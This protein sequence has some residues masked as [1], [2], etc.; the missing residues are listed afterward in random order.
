MDRCEPCLSNM[1]TCLSHS[2]FPSAGAAHMALSI[3]SLTT[4]YHCEAIVT[5]PHCLHHFI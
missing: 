5:N 1:V 4:H 3:P 2:A